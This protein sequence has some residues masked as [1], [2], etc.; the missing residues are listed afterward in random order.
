M[1]N[2]NDSD[3]VR[4]LAGGIQADTLRLDTDLL[5]DAYIAELNHFVGCLRSGEKPLASGEDARAALAIARACIESFQQ[6]S[7]VRVQGAH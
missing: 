7:T 1:G 4:Y 5:R 6:G 2:V 3:L